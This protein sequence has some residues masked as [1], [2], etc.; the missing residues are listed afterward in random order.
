MSMKPQTAGWIFTPTG[1]PFFTPVNMAP[2]SCGG[3]NTNFFIC[4]W[5]FMYDSSFCSYSKGENIFFEKIWIKLISTP[6]GVKKRKMGVNWL[7]TRYVQIS[8]FFVFRII[9]WCRWLFVLVILNVYEATNSELDIHLHWF[10]PPLI[11]LPLGRGSEN[12]NF[13]ICW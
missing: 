10:S 11:M 12:T 2:R 6:F 9:S 8:S 1:N 7:Y 4:W 3:E 13:F 5:I